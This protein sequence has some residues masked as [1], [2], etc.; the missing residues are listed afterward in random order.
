MLAYAIESWLAWTHCFARDILA[1]DQKTK[2]LSTQMKRSKG[3][4]PI[5]ALAGAV[6]LSLAAQL[7]PNAHGTDGLP[8]R[9][10]VWKPRSKRPTSKSAASRHV[11]P[12]A[13]AQAGRGADGRL[14]VSK[15]AR[16]HQ[17]RTYARESTRELDLKVRP[18][19]KMHQ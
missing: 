5:S 12:T 2:L 14:C 16:R 17:I 19:L 4:M 13:I 11:G 18:R 9:V 6:V 8:A 1:V 7:R 15:A 3:T 10:V